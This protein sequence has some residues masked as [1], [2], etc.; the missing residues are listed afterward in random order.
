MNNLALTEIEIDTLSGFVAELLDDNSSV[1]DST[2]KT[3]DSIYRKLEHS[4]EGE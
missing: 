4:T 3:L 1:S 2:R